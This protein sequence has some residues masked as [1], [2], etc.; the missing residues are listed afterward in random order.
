[1][2]R[3]NVIS[4][5]ATFVLATLACLLLAVVAPTLFGPRAIDEPFAGYAVMASPRDLHV[6]TAPIRLST[7]PDLTLSRGTLYADGN[8]AAGTPISRFVLD[9]PV[10][11][12]NASGLNPNESEFESPLAGTLRDAVAPVLVEQLQAMGFESLTVR[13]GILI[14][15]AG[16]GTSETIAEIEAELTG[17]RKGE[18]AG[19]G[20][21]AFRGQ[22][23]GFDGILTQPADKSARW[24][25]KLSLKGDLLAATV[26]GRLDVAHDLQ[27]G[28]EV[29]LTSPSLRRTAR[30]FGV[31]MPVTDG[32]NAVAVK[33]QINWTGRAVAVENA[34][35]TI[36]GNEATGALVLNLPGERPLIGATLAFQAL[37]LTPYAE[38]ARAQSFLFDR[39]TA[40]W[41]L[42]D[43]SF[44]LIRHVDADLRISAPKVVLKGYG[45]GRGAAT[46]AVR[47]GKLLADVAELDLFGGKL[48]AQIT[49]NADEIVP[50]YALRGRVE[51]F[52]TSS[53]AS[54]LFGSP[55]LSGRGTLTVEIEGVGQTPAEVVRRLSGKAALTMPDG[56][57]LALDMKALRSA[58]K[59]NS[60]PG[61]AP[62]TKGQTNLELV[63]ARALMRNGVLT[64]ELVQARSGALGLSAAG[65][66]DL[67]QRTLDLSLFMK[68]SVPTDRPLKAS[69][70]AGA[71][72]VTLRGPWLEPMV[73]DQEPEGG[74]AR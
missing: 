4:R 3:K 24:P 40:T 51:S 2:R 22:R 48:S 20:S 37:D 47:S 67:A 64:T 59:A 21:F 41:S 68:A 6:V 52:E 9:A 70:M 27:L 18:V 17:R 10:F 38:A 12:L 66:V 8:A 1:M 34:K 19:H 61:W 74:T 29:E 30:W 63:E 65:W 55:A 46:I 72:T 50:R 54:L 26:D 5:L 31:P 32:L 33:G 62:L 53:A 25:L 60:P 43:L 13:Q 44:P 11:N 57:R 39:Q 45:L 7:A 14:V 56:G 15:T 35:V 42:F 58:A 28:G 16:D 36:D 71:E 69:D 73:R 23:L 49:A